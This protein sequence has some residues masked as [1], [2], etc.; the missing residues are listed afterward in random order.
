[1][2]ASTIRP[3]RLDPVA[4]AAAALLAM[5]VIA[6]GAD[7]RPGATAILSWEAPGDDDLVG[8]ATRYQVRYRV[9]PLYN[10][11]T[12]TYWNA[13]TIVGGVPAPGW[14]GTTDSLVVTGLDPSITYYFIV[15]A[16]DEAPNW[17]GFSNIVVKPALPDHVPPATIEDLSSNTSSLGVPVRSDSLRATTTPT[18]PR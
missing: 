18:P 3:L 7:D 6:R 16:A 11:D 1:M 9:V 8:T 4:L 17:S 15:R 2:S 5:P 12:L 14:P 13:G 10:A